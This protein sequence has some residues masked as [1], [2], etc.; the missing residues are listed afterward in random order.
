MMASSFCSGV[1]AP[2]QALTAF[3][4]LKPPEGPNA[5]Y[6]VE[7]LWMETLDLSHH[8]LKD[9]KQSGEALGWCWPAWFAGRW[10]QKPPKVPAQEMMGAEL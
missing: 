3:L 1:S 8:H 9:L 5:V 2:C 7:G 6:I 4:P 10:K